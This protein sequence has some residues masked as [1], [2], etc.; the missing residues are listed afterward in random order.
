M[1]KSDKQVKDKL[2]KLSK[3]LGEFDSKKLS[4]KKN[5]SNNTFFKTSEVIILL[6]ITMIVSLT[7][8]GLVTYKLYFNKGRNIDRNL[9]EFI[10]NYD[11]IT[12]SYYGDVDKG[13]LIDSAI[14]GMLSS[15]DENSAYVGDKNNNFNIYLEGNY[16][17]IGISVYNDESGNAVIYSV[18]DNTPAKKTGLKSGDV[19]IK[20][21][22]ESVLGKSTTDISSIIKKQNNEFKMTI[23]RGDEEKEIKINKSVINLTSVFS[24]IIKKDGKSI[25]YIYTN[26]FANNTYDQ[27]KGKLEKLE[28]ENIDSLIIDLRE[29]NGGH[30][31]AAEDIVSLFLDSSH[32][33]Y[34]IKSKESVSEYYS[35]GKENKKYKIVML[36]NGNSAS[37]SELTTSALK[38]QYGATIV[39]EKTYGKGTVQELQTLP[40]GNRYKLTTKTWVT[41]KGS[42]VDHKGIKPDIEVKLDDNY[43]K[44]P[45]DDNDNQLKTAIDE[46][47]K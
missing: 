35:K 3:T 24:K 40:N 42:K 23:K 43:Y 13:K 10:K 19:I 16:K 5:K 21:N 9:Q 14:S 22:K 12:N 28:K 7:M 38:E 36:V 32:P 30:L 6:L 41:S 37:A 34:R 20:I 45:N 2:K 18:M 47:I 26:I 46:A 27:F 39:G 1:K 25:G 33:I 4:Y 44:N 17:G 11:Y 31:T 29:N 8:G 15:L